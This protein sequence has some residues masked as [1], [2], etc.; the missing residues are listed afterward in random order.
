MTNAGLERSR[1]MEAI[2]Q[3]SEALNLATA[4]HG[5][6]I[7]MEETRTVARELKRAISDLEKGLATLREENGPRWDAAG[8]LESA[9]RYL[10]QLNRSELAEALQHANLA[11][12]EIAEHRPT[13]GGGSVPV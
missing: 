7:L 12:K 4:I 6:W 8:P 11:F 5:K 10:Y 9:A 1:R 3:T 13:S 2:R